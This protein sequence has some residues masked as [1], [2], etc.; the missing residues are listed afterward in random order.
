MSYEDNELPSVLKRSPGFAFTAAATTSFTGS[1]RN[2]HIQQ[3]DI[4]FGPILTHKFYRGRTLGG[5]EDLEAGLTEHLHNGLAEAILSINNQDGATLRGQPL[6]SV[7]GF[8]GT[9]SR[10]RSLHRRQQHL[11]CGSLVRFTRQMNHSAETTNDSLHDRQA[12]SAAR[13]FG[14]EDVLVLKK[15]SNALATG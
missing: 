7:V 13:R 15:R 5:F 11:K 8:Q 10:G 14:G 12:K 3:N 1:A 2:P 6:L 9:A 4:D